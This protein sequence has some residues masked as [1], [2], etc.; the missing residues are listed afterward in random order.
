M[1]T[2]SEKKFTT[3]PLDRESFRSLFSLF[4]SFS[5]HRIFHFFFHIFHLKY[6][7][8]N[9]HLIAIC[10]SYGN[11][12]RIEFSS[13]FQASIIILQLNKQFEPWFWHFF[14]RNFKTGWNG[15]RSLMLRAPLSVYRGNDFRESTPLPISRKWF[16]HRKVRF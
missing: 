8:I 12:V 11:T 6:Y 3:A 15:K 9:F 5:L 7:I 14:Q 2:S 13:E 4:L 16:P 10:F 1:S